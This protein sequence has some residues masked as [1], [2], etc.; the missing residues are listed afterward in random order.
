MSAGLWYTLSYTFEK[1]IDKGQQ[2]EMGGDGFMARYVD[3]S[4]IPQIL[5]VAL[6][7]SLPFGRGQRFMNKANAAC[8][9]RPGGLAVPDHQ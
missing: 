4:N 1:N 5:T 2:V 7:Y 9:R 6:G 3:G 8:E